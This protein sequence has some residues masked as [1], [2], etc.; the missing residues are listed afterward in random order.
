MRR[1]LQLSAILVA[2][3]A[4]RADIITSLSFA[5][6]TAG[7][8][9]TV[10]V[11][12]NVTV[13]LGIAFNPLPATMPS[14][15]FVDINTSSQ[16]GS[17]TTD[18]NPCVETQTYTN[19]SSLVNTPNNPFVEIIANP[20]L[21]RVPDFFPFTGVG[22]FPLTLTYPNTGLFEVDL[23][24]PSTDQEQIPEIQCETLFTAGIPGSPTCSTI[25]ILPVAGTVTGL[26]QQLFVNVVAAL[27]PPAAVP[28]PPTALLVV[29]GS[30]AA[31]A[32]TGIARRS[33]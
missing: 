20:N 12:S 16:V 8:E 23:A 30:L 11:G 2:T 18:P 15:Q 33:A 21:T 27:P 25:A 6:P 29:A 24:G 9:L 10:A 26:G 1:L 14:T 4:V 5:D 3:A 28:E 19:A 22:T 7:S 31:L 32:F 17:C 13:N